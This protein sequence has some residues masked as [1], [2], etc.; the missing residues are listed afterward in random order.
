[1]KV[2]LIK[3]GGSAITQKDQP[4]KARPEA[5]ASLLS[6]LAQ[7]R[8]QRPELTIILGHGAG[9]FG[10]YAVEEY[11]LTNAVGISRIHQAMLQ[12]NQMVVAKAIEYSLPMMPMPPSIWYPISQSSAFASH[13]KTILAAD[14]IP[15]VFGDVLIQ[16]DQSATILSTEM[17][18][19]R[20]FP[21][22]MTFATVSMVIN[23]GNVPGLL[24]GT[25]DVIPR[26]TPAN[27]PQLQSHITPTHG[28]D[29]TGGIRH[30]VEESLALTKHGV[31]SLFVDWR[32]N[33][34]T[35]ALTEQ[36]RV[37]TVIASS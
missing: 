19:A 4:M 22:V 2:V 25:N 17:V 36:E 1:M 24:D 18:F 3:L 23:V 29:V 30:K 14:Q 12:L 7:I 31:S 26:I 37:G 16:P 8:K 21:V 20:L 11:G 6:Q 5:I 13:L 34:L 9:S 10:H 27:W 32:G 35:K 15:C 33:S 28:F